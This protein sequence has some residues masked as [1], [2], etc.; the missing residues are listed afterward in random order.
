MLFLVFCYLLR[1]RCRRVSSCV[2]DS[3]TDVPICTDIATVHSCLVYFINLSPDIFRQSTH[4]LCRQRFKNS[5]KRRENYNRGLNSC[6]HIESYNK[7]KPY[8]IC[9]NGAIDGHS[10]FILLL[11]AFTTNSD[12]KINANYYTDRVMC[13]NGCPSRIRVDLGTENRHMCQMQSALRWDND[14]VFSKKI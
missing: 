11:K 10:R 12:P 3:V 7:L 1:G 13:R 14:V 6:W 2:G 9:I 5:L 8:G 4:S